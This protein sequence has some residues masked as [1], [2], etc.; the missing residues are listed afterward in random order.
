MG[1]KEIKKEI[2]TLAKNEWRN[3]KEK[4]CMYRD[5]TGKR[6][7]RITS[8]SECKR[9]RYY[10]PTQEAVYEA[11]LN[12]IKRNDLDR[13]AMTAQQVRSGI[14]LETAKL[15]DL[16]DELRQARLRTAPEKLNKIVKRINELILGRGDDVEI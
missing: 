7:C 9:C 11:A 6:F 13:D 2:I 1:Y 15:A 14:L 3:E 8:L 4:T 10:E 5:R 16:V 12:T